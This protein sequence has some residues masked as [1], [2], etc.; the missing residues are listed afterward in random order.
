M[1]NK[2]PLVRIKKDIN[3]LGIEDL[4]KEIIQSPDSKLQVANKLSYGGAFGI[5]GSALQLIGT[6]LRNS[7]SHEVRTSIHNLDEESFEDLCNSLFGLCLLRISDSIQLANGAPV[8][9][10]TAL[11]PAI[12]ISQSIQTGDFKSSFKGMYLALP[13]I[14]SVIKDGQKDREFHSPLY[15]GTSVVGQKRFRELTVKALHAMAP[16]AA[17]LSE[18][19]TS[20][21]S[22]ILRE[23]FTNTHKHARTDYQGN[24]LNKNFRG[25]IFRSISLDAQRLDEL[26]KAGGASLTMFIGDWRPEGNRLFR[27]LD[28]SVVDAGPGYARR[29][30]NKGGNELSMEEEAASVVECFKKHRS[31]DMTDSSGSGLSNVL[32]D[33]KS[34]RGWFRLRTGRILV[35]K[36]FFNGSGSTEIELN[37]IRSKEAFLEGVS[38]NVVIPFKSL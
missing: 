2:T 23:L 15:N 33:L 20:N 37:E 28:I 8:D 17:K 21:L 25:I 6:W 22:E 36:S 30:S 32:R 13:A 11:Q 9:L 38:F 31:T 19:A 5:E 1:P 16:E 34:L 24:P 3:F 12:P 10:M 14:K 4:A 29:W 7:E 26:S 27:A 35:E 18:D